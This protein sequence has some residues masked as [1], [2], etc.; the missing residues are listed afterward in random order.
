MTTN[1]QLIKCYKGKA[2]LQQNLTLNEI[3]HSVYVDSALS[4]NIYID[5]MSYFGKK[6]MQEPCFWQSVSLDSQKN[7]IKYINIMACTLLHVREIFVQ[8]L[9]FMLGELNGNLEVKQ[10][11]WNFIPK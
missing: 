2:F 11:H 9:V 5:E 1:Y 7:I 4:D 8:L 6:Y 3:L 10:F